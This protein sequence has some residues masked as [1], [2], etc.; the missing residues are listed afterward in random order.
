MLNMGAVSAENMFASAHA[1]NTMMTW[2][3]RL[4][5]V[6]LVCFGIALILAP[7][8]V[9]ASVVP[10]IGKIVG[11]GTG[12]FSLF[13]GTAWSLLIIAVAW[14]FYRPLIGILLLAAA[15]LLIIGLYSKRHTGKGNDGKG[16]DTV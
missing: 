4:V 13:F 2:I 11:I 1:S 8:E 6:C 3:L 5:G 14:L 12:L 15:V 7:L 16:K 10:F 9:L